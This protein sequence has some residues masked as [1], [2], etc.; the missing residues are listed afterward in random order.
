MKFIYFLT[1]KYLLSIFADK[2][3]RLPALISIIS[4]FISVF[5]LLVVMFVMKGF[6]I[7]V[8]NKI[9][10]NFPHIILSNKSENNLDNIENIISYSNSLQGYG[11]YIVGD[12]FEL[13]KLKAQA[14]INTDSDIDDKNIYYANVSKDFLLLNF[15]PKISF[16][17][18]K[19][20]CLLYNH[21]TK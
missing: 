20:F 11:A 3:L 13:I 19:F 16:F 18:K 7:K 1:K 4:I 12:R 2:T 9:L 6:E 14:N 8:Q 5:S 21:I 10:E 15:F 17:L